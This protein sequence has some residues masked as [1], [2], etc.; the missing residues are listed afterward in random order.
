MDKKKISKQFFI[1]VS[2][3][4]DKISNQKHFL[5][6]IENWHSKE[7]CLQKIVIQK[8]AYYSKN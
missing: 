5:K 3:V 4:E 2:K 8:K 6:Y 7:K 1:I